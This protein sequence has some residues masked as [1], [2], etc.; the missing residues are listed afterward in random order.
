MDHAM[1]QLPKLA[2]PL[3][4]AL[5]LIGIVRAYPELLRPHAT[6]DWFARPE[7]PAVHEPMQGRAQSDAALGRVTFQYRGGL[8]RTG[9]ERATTN[10]SELGPYGAEWKSQGMNVGVHDA[11]KS[12]PAVDESGV[13]VGTD[14]GWIEAFEHDGRLRWKMHVASAERGVHATAALDERRLYIGAY[15]GS[16]YALDKASG[17]VAWAVRL[18][19]T[20]GSS[21]AID[22]DAIYVSVETFHP[23]DGYVAKLDRRS[24]RVLWRSAWL[25]EQSHS[26]PTIDRENGLVFVGSNNAR[27]RALRARDGAEAWSIATRGPVKDT[28]ALVL[29]RVYFTSLKGVLYAADARTGNVAWTAQLGGNTRSS[30]SY[31]PEADVFLVGSNDGSLNAVRREDGSL[32]WSRPTATEDMIGSALV[33]RD[34]EEGWVAW[35]VCAP[36]TL[37]RLAG[38]NG[39]ELARVPL[40]APLTGVPA[41]FGDA[42]YVATNA[43][44]GLVRL[45]PRERE[46]RLV[47]R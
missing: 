13:Y 32:A 43:P 33:R 16:F 26:S 37:C 29:G 47:A 9:I 34:A 7:R 21:A 46:A 31:V 30:P 28:G 36:S 15:N 5:V 17:D 11:S 40:G 44:G 35:A 39:A 27:Y 2:F 6:R 20:I 18:G 25:G 12:S 10:A 1:K 38:S 14:G 8:D 19:D 4:A 42:I 23:P 45:G 22:G 41:A 3:Y 24:G